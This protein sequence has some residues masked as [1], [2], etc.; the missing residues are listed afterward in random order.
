M[1]NLEHNRTT[2]EG[3]AAGFH[4]ARLT[5]IE[6]GKLMSSGEWHQDERCASCALRM[7]TVPNGCPQTILDVTKCV[8]EKKTFNCH[9]ARGDCPAGT[10]PCMG[11]FAAM[12]LGGGPRKRAAVKAPWEFSPPDPI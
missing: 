3:R 4:L 9:V 11:W 5:D 7:G 6:V 12:Q 8:L 2:A 10:H 1:S